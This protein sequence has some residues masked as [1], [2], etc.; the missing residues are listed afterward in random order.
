VGEVTTGERKLQLPFALNL[1][2]S[3]WTFHFEHGSQ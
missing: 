2:Y 3:T 1:L